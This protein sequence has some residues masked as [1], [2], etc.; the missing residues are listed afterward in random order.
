M[1]VVVHRN[2]G[3]RLFTP[4]M[5]GQT[6]TYTGGRKTAATSVLAQENQDQNN[7]D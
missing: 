3:H 7:Y 2:L 1:H 4:V 6:S 5:P